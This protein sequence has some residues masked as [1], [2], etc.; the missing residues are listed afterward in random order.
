MKLAR[1][2]GITMELLTKR[3]VTATDLAA[4]FEVSIRTI[5][6]D[7]ELINQAGVPVASFSGADGGFELMNGFFLTKQTFSLDDLLLIYSLLKGWIQPLVVDLRISWVHCSQRL[8]A[9]KC[10]KKWSWKSG[11]LKKKGAS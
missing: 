1:L 10:R 6:R 2:L 3:R 9:R 7:I 11:H 5:Y 8:R 4:R